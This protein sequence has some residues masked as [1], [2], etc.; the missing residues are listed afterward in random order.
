MRFCAARKP[1]IYRRVGA[2][3]GLDAAALDDSAADLATIAFLSRFLD[4]LG[5]GSRLS[6]HGVSRTHLDALVEQAIA[7]PCHRSNV[8]PVDQDGL[9]ALYLEVL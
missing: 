1:G 2:A 7:D 8:V 3:C 6:E 4:G 5:L 9:R